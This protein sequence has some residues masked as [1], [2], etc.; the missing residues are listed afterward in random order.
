MQRRAPHLPPPPPAGEGASAARASSR[1]SLVFGRALSRTPTT[2]NTPRMSLPLVW[3]K[4]GTTHPPTKGSVGPPRQITRGMGRRDNHPPPTRTAGGS[5]RTCDEPCPRAG[6]SSS[7]KVLPL[8]DPR[9][10]TRSFPAS[11]PPSPCPRVVCCV[12]SRRTCALR[13]AIHSAST[14]VHTS[15]CPSP[16]TRRNGDGENAALP[17]VRKPLPRQLLN[18]QWLRPGRSPRR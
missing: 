6:V 10:A 16:S 17:F 1:S 2:T 12:Y 9:G 14:D 11:L 8:D 5:L 18:E 3:P 4:T 15:P 13:V 7:P